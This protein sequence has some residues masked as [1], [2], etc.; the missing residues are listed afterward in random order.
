MRA[1]ILQ[2]WLTGAVLLMA[3]LLGPLRASPS[4]TEHTLCSVLR[5]QAVA[6]RIPFEERVG[7]AQNPAGRKL[8]E[9]M[10]RKRSNLAVAADVDTV[11]EMLRI[12]DAAGPHIAVFK[13]HV[14]IFDEWSSDIAAQLQRLAEKHG[15]T[16]S[17]SRHLGILVRSMKEML[18]VAMM[19]VHFT[20]I[21]MY[22]PTP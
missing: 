21:E 14:D 7:L 2:T 5:Y 11:Q 16:P 13:T 1:H 20:P 15:E 12:A 10:V 17:H 6:C 4:G 8:F 9:L 22:R 3:V 19:M 18:V